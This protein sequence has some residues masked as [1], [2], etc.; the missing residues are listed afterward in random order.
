MTSKFEQLIE[1]VI[2]DEEAKAKELFHDIV[3]EKSRE[4]YENLMN[5]ESDAEEDDHAERAANKVKDEIEYDDAKDKKD[6][7]DEDE[8]DDEE[9]IEEDMGDT[10]GSASQDLMREVETDEQGMTE[11]SDAEFDDEA[12]EDGEDLTHDIEADHDAGEGD[13]ENRVVDLEDKLDE[14]MAEFEALMGDETE[15]HGDDEFD[16]E[17]VDGDVGG[18]AYADDDTSEFQDMPMSENISLAKVAAP[19]HGDNGANS[20]SP[21]AANSGAA[22]MAAKPVRNTASESNPDGTSAYK[23]P[24]SYAD[25]GRGNL[26][27]AGQFKNVPAKN[28]SKLEAAPKPTLAQ[29]TGVNTKTPFPKG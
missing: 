12:E 25:K 21:V 13:I 6:R 15:E 7:T 19:T 22:G 8:E 14:L 28:G 4:I 5:E 24:T 17:P 23:A 10:S 16:M 18:D 27:G 11:E 3:V 26:P 9:P 1:Y 2:N 20:K 29:A